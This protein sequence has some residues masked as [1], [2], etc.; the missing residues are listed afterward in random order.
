MKTL[1]FCL[2]KSDFG[3]LKS[4]AN[5]PEYA[6]HVASLVYV[7][8]MLS[9]KRHEFDSHAKQLQ[10]DEDFRHLALTDE[11]IR[12]YYETYEQAFE[13]QQEI[14][15]YNRDFEVLEG[16]IS[17]LPNL[18]EIVVWS[19]PNGANAGIA[20]M[21]PTD[22]VHW[23]FD[24][25]GLWGTA[26]SESGIDYEDGPSRHLRALLRGVHNA[27]TQL[28]KIRAAGMHHS[29]FNPEHFGLAHMT[30]LFENLTCFEIS[31]GAFAE[32]DYTWHE[33]RYILAPHVI[34][35][36]ACRTTMQKGVLRTALLKM[37]NLVTLRLI[38]Y[39][40]MRDWRLVNG[41][42]PPPSLEDM[43]PTEQ[44]W[45]K[46]ESLTLEG[47]Y[48]DQEQL[49]TLILKHRDTLTSLELSKVRIL[50]GSWRRLL[51]HL[52]VGLAAKKPVIKLGY[53]PEDW[54]DG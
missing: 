7:A 53:D 19:T 36:S 10:L 2:S 44:L 29:F 14:L 34:D 48:A 43:V 31:I 42:C 46:L 23:P 38:I 50:S 5:R 35:G 24:R 51:P 25:V 12:G 26:I 6:E 40:L 39:G 22:R 1:Q 45:S 37:P 28:R 54:S 21:G 4:I 8:E 27:G 9:S 11:E 47:M 15:T 20:A 18:D 30:H 32:W 17:K 49:A 16:V 52:K 33:D 3:I 41:S 13:E